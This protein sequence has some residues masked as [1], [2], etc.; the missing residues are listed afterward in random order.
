MRGGGMSGECRTREARTNG[1]H[2]L[3]KTSS[4]GTGWGQIGAK[5]CHPAAE[6]LGVLADRACC[7]CAREDDSPSTDLST[8]RHGSQVPEA[9]GKAVAVIAKKDAEGLSQREVGNVRA[10]VR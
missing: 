9:N 2:G 10:E 3:P 7:A 4:R 5:P 8:A 1:E 6:A